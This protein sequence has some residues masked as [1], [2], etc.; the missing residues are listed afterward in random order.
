MDVLPNYIGGQWIASASLEHQDVFNPALGSVIARV[1]L[2]TREEVDRA[3]QA[4]RRAWPEWRETPPAVRARVLFTFRATLEAHLDELARIVTTE[5]GK[6][7]DEARGSIRRGIECVE[8]ACHAPSLM[9][10]LALDNVA[11]G[12]DCQMARHPL[13]VVAVIPPFNFPVMVPLWFLPFALA[14]GNTVVVKPSEQ[15]P[16]SMKRVVELLAACGLPDGA[17]SLVNGSREVAEALCDHPEIKAVSFVGS[18]AVARRVYHRAAASGKRV[19]ALGGAKNFIVVMPDADLEHAMPAIAE[20]FFGCAGERCLAGAVL[21]PVGYMHAHVRAQFV[22]A[23]RTLRVGDGTDARTTMGP[24]I[25]AQ[26]RLRVMEYIVRG[27]A[28]GAKLLLDGRGVKVP[29]RPDGFFL[30]AS[31]FDEV[32]PTMAI[33]RDEIFGPV[34]SIMA[35]RDLNEAISII[36][37]HPSANAASIFTAS[38]KAAREF[39]RRVPASM[40]GVNLGI[41]APMAQFPFGGSRD[42]FFGDLKA[43]GRD[44][45][46]F[47][48]EKKVVMSRWF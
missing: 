34:A 39:S 15:V 6:T 3:V 35:V 48:T 26:H 25:S 1:P 22:D 5:N 45:F 42:S 23:A 18:T 28:E 36:D 17:V 10:G 9:M 40:V 2:S 21:M 33:A 37:A 27:V 19:Q 44:A 12:I 41:A 47:Y 30:G 4:A 13:G 29:G 46:E 7:L 11:P 8:A 31:V 38:G 24:L 32:K 16:L 14:T 20:S 43:H